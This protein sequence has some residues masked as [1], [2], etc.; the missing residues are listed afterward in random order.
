[1]EDPHG[2]DLTAKDLLND[3]GI[4]PPFHEKINARCR[5]ADLPFVIHF[6]E[7]DPETGEPRTCCITRLGAPTRGTCRNLA[8]S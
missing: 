7:W 6:D 2:F 5:F 4:E 8:Q 1:M 3:F